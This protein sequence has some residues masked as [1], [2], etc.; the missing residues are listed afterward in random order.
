MRRQ[1]LW[2]EYYSAATFL[3]FLVQKSF[4]HPNFL[5]VSEW[6]KME[7]FSNYFAN[8]QLVVEHLY[9]EIQIWVSYYSLSSYLISSE[10]KFSLNEYFHHFR[11]NK[12]RYIHSFP[13]YNVNIS[14]T[15]L[16]KVTFDF[17]CQNHFCEL[18]WRNYL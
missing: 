2:S 11:S 7:T 12:V 18:F 1:F 15:N 6:F 8:L 9:T 13:H 10:T 5:E 3:M 17:L 16:T 14:F 4:F